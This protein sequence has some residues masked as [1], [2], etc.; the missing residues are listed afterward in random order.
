MYNNVVNFLAQTDRFASQDLNVSSGATGID[1]VLSVC[2]FLFFFLS[3]FDAQ[4]PTN[5]QFMKMV[6]PKNILY[7]STEEKRHLNLGWPES[8]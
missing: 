6:S 5:V 2:F 3:F 4:K 8:Q 7:G 1:L